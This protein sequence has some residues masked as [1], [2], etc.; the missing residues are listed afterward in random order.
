MG[1]PRWMLGVLLLITAA[2]CGDGAGADIGVDTATLKAAVDHPL[3][4][5]SSVRTAVY[6]GATTEDGKPVQLRVESQVSDATSTVAGVEVT[7]VIVRD[8]ENGALIES[9]QDY[10]AQDGAGTV[11]YLGERV[12]DIE[13]GKVVGHSGQ[14]LAGE[15]GNRA[16]IFMP[17]Q[18]GVGATFE[19][20]RA[21]GVAEDR[22]TVVA[23]DL[24]V[25]V[26]AGVFEGCIETEDVN[27]LDDVTEHKF[28]CPGA[29]LVREVYPEGGSLE[30][31][32]LERRG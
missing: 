1:T 15:D 27:P 21:P 14:W 19:Q 7:T 24:T 8:L 11:Y 20:E 31:I 3:V 10:Y 23:T 29:G 9:T 5:L 18:V 4:A 13:G 2:A 25:T 30:L 6:A 16:G 26:P 28:Y 17:A 12:D 32:S 22:S